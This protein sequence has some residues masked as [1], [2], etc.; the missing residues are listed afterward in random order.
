MYEIVQ[1]FIFKRRM[2]LKDCND[3]DRRLRFI[4]N[5]SISVEIGSVLVLE[6]E[7]FIALD[8][9]ETLASLG[10]SFVATLD[11]R[12]A[13]LE[14]LASN[15]ANLAVID[16]RLNDGICHDVAERLSQQQIPFIV[17]AGA[18]VEGIGAQAFSRGHWL[19]KPA[20]PD[21]FQDAVRRLLVR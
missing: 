15:R 7:P 16:P 18:L 13:A 8:V 19:W 4:P 14:W 20:A 1:I 12:A 11:T 2:F 9:E 10:A 3:L 21:E 5:W 17:Y 6:N